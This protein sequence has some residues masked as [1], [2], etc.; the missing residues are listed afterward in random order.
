MVQIYHASLVGKSSAGDFVWY[1]DVKDKLELAELILDG[2]VYQKFSTQ[3]QSWW[4]FKIEFEK[5][6]YDTRQKLVELISKIKEV[7]E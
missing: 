4:E 3:Y 5:N 1:K 6:D 7:Q 2:I